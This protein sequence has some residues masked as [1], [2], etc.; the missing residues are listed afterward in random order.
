MDKINEADTILVF[1]CGVGVQTFAAMFE[2]KRVYSCCDTYPL[3]GFQG[4]TPLTVACAQCGECY[5]NYTVEYVRSLHVQKVWSMASVVEQR[6]AC[7]KSTRLCNADGNGF[8]ESL[9]S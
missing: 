8:T 2:E 3:P 4:V 7:V 6:M 9:K 5:L 1:S